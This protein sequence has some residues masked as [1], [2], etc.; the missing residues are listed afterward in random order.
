MR[1]AAAVLLTLALA[2]P[3]PAAE[4]PNI[5]FLTC[6]DISPNL[7]CYGDPDA[8]TPNLDRLAAQGARF[9]RAFSHSPVCAPTRSGIITGMYPTTMGSHHMRSKLTKAPPLFTDYLKKAGY[10]V[11]WPAGGGIGKTDFNFD[12]PKGWA[13]VTDD[14]T[15]KPEVLKPPF[16]AVY[17]ITVTHESQARATRFQYAKNTARLKPNERRDPNKVRLPP[18]YPD[19][20]AVRDCVATYHDNITAMDYVVGDVLKVLDDNKLG[21]NTVVI[22]YGDHGAGLSR[23]KRWPYD[24]GLRVPFLVRWPGQVRPGSVREDLTCFLDLAPTALALAGAEVPPHMQGRVFL[25]EKARPAPKY[26][27][28]ARDR[29]DETYDRIRSVRGERYRYVRNFHPELPYMQYI[30]YMDEMPIMRDWRRLAFEGKLNPTQM[31]FMS[32]TKPEEE[33]YDLDAD[34][35]EV[36]NLAGDP[37]HQPVL[38]EMRAALDKWMIDTKDLGEVPEKELIKRGLVRDV[39]STEYDARV[40]LHPNTPPVP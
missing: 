22:F 40:K 18:Y 17:N 33:L 34:P 15:K 11:C 20:W 28:A 29:M 26:V 39:L 8:I 36:K 5:V 4:R 13:D 21:E 1:P 7:G 2:P 14:W 23:A 24:S 32:R 35:H 10:T 30:N 37:A 31:L 19:T 9:T 16:F 25:G 12:P 27:F 6:E 3:V 38:K